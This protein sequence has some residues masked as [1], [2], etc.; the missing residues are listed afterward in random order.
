LGL[1]WQSKALPVIAQMVSLV[2]SSP[3]DL[4]FSLITFFEARIKNSPLKLVFHFL[5]PMV[6]FPGT[7]SSAYGLP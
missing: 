1:L 4:Q 6:I 7:K 3:R 2:C 5:N